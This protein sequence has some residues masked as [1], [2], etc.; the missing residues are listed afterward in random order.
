MQATR[1]PPRVLCE[2]TSAWHA[3]PL[4]HQGQRTLR[5]LACIKPRRQVE[6]RCAPLPE[7][8]GKNWLA[9]RPTT[10]LVRNQ[11]LRLRC[12]GCQRFLRQPQYWSLM[13]CQFLFSRVLL[14]NPIATRSDTGPCWSLTSRG[15]ALLLPIL[16]GLRP[17]GPRPIQAPPLACPRHRGGVLSWQMSDPCEECI[18]IAMGNASS[19]SS[20]SG[21]MPME[22]TA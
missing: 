4:A 6:R 12:V 16:L 18:A 1:W 11:S 14:K 8:G 15:V 17:L 19:S 9:L 3:A 2:F 21:L 20:S 7:A 22:S 10:S 13:L 5:S